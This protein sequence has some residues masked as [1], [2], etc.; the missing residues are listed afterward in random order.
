LVEV[1]LRNPVAETLMW[2][3]Y[4][5]MIYND[6]YARHL[7]RAPSRPAGHAGVRGVAR[8]GRL[9]RRLFYTAVFG[10]D[11]QVEGVLAAIIE[12]TGQV[13]AQRARSL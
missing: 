8:S 12:I 5:V 9:Q 7:R 2:D 6:A 1:M 13:L 10:D 4:G 11:G 3:P